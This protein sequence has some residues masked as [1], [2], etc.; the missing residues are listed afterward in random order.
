M[1]NQELAKI[2]KRVQSNKEKYFKDLFIEIYRTIYYLSFKFLEN[3]SEAQDVSQEI[4][5]SIYNHI[6]ELKVPESFNRWM[7]RIIYS[8]CKDRKKQL[9]NRK[10]EDYK[11]VYEKLEEQTLVDNPEHVLQKKE[12][13][14][15]ILEVIDDLPMKQKEVILLYYYQQLTAPEI[16]KVLS[17]SVYSIQNRLYYAKKSIRERVEKSKAYTKEQLFSISGIPVLFIIFNEAAKEVA[18]I[19]M[20]NWLWTRF[21]AKKKIIGNGITSGNKS[22]KYKTNMVRIALKISSTTLILI[23]VSLALIVYKGIEEKNGQIKELARIQEQSIE[24]KVQSVIIR[25]NEFEVTE[26]TIPSKD[27]IEKRETSLQPEVTVVE[28]TQDNI[29]VQTEDKSQQVE[30]ESQLIEPRSGNIVLVDI[31]TEE[32]ISIW[33]NKERIFTNSALMEDLELETSKQA[34]ATSNKEKNEAVYE[35]EVYKKDSETVYHKVVGPTLS[36]SKSSYWEQD[37]IIYYLHI[38]NIGTVAANNIIIKDIVPNY[39]KFVQMLTP[40]SEV[41]IEVSEIYKENSETI[42]WLINQLN[43]NQEI[44]LAFQVQVEEKEYQNNREIKNIAFLKVVEN[45]EDIGN[46]LEE[47]QGY[48]ESNQIV[49][50]MQLQGEIAPQ[51]GER[52]EN[53]RVYILL[54]VISIIVG[55]YT[56]SKKKKVEH[57]D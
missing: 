24:Q 50:K 39:T 40:Q 12:K 57:S 44:T 53:I 31:S 41:A 56:R 21:T 16:A 4:M 36:F 23:S 9:S 22:M 33:N 43:S 3:E 30:D 15:F 19:E 42:F 32:N 37:K 13:N 8:K 29:L 27:G 47:A 5:L 45:N 11:E 35:E 1:N 17:C 6:D 54:M 52:T 46:Q 7:N 10:E 51:T 55:S 20:G 48:I 28:E 38:K 34:H 49:H 18:K 26:N 14:E 25:P 2:V